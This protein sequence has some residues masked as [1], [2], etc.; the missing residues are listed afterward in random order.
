MLSYKKSK[1]LSE[2]SKH[3]SKFERNNSNKQ[4]DHDGMC[5]MQNEVY[6]NLLQ[7]ILIAIP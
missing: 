4:N 1:R 2:F 5:F 6:I 7:N 3:K